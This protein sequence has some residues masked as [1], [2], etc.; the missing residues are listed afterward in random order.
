[1]TQVRKK[2]SVISFQLKLYLVYTHDVDCNTL[3][4]SSVERRH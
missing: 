4:F 3:Y 2:Q 1:M